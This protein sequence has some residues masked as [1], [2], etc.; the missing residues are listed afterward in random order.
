MITRKDVDTGASLKLT[1][2]KCIFEKVFLPL[3]YEKEDAKNIISFNTIF[4]GHM[5]LFTNL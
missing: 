3:R 5:R 2:Y 4:I 1:E